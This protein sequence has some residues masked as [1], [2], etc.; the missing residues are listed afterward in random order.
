MK[1]KEYKKM[2]DMK[3]EK[4]IAN[5]AASLA[6][7]GSIVTSEETEIVRKYLKGQL[8]EKELLEII[9]NSGKS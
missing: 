9:K 3:I 4:I 2:D 1:N 5:A 7:E 6:I 8:T